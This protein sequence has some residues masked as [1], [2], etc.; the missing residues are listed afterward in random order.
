[1]IHWI[2]NNEDFDIAGIIITGGEYDSYYNY[3]LKT[4]EVYDVST[5]QHCTLP[6]LPERRL[7]HTQVTFDG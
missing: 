7:G 6:D 4:A 5:G 1:M 3:E 2:N